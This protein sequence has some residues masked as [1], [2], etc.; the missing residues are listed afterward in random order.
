MTD[1]AL[2]FTPITPVHFGKHAVLT[3]DQRFHIFH[4][5]NPHIYRNLHALA[6]H[7]KRLGLKYSINA[8]YE[9]L[10]WD[11]GV[12]TK[13]DAFTL[14]NNYRALYARMLMDRSPEL[15]GYFETRSRRSAVTRQAVLNGMVTA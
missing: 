7:A 5:R 4:S 3:I 15:A 6:L 13:G 2:D 14:N 8:L 10:R 12:A 11:Y 1:P 9:K